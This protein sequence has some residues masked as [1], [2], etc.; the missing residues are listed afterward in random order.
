MTERIKAF[1]WYIWFPKSH[2]E[3]FLAI[4]TRPRHGD[5]ASW[6][7]DNEYGWV[8]YLSISPLE[9]TEERPTREQGR[10]LMKL[11]WKGHK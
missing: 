5:P 4:K 1:N 6:K 10:R 11:I 3:L 2:H 8:N 7:L 9:L